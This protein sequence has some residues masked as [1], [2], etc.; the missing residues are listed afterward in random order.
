MEVEVTHT[1]I[2]YPIN[3]WRYEIEERSCAGALEFW[4]WRVGIHENARKMPRVIAVC[5]TFEEAK[6]E[7]E[8]AHRRSGA[9]CLF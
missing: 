2:L 4:A 3:G 1:D 8:K 9:A 6:A 7:A 5:L